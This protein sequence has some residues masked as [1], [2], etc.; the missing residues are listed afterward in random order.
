M[1]NEN[2]HMLVK[3]ATAIAFLAISAGVVL[4]QKKHEG[5]TALRRSRRKKKEIG[6]VNIG[7]KGDS[8]TY[9]S[10]VVLIKPCVV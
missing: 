5:A 8:P 6:A 3:L 1:D 2:T 7:G 9:Y 10:C 4:H